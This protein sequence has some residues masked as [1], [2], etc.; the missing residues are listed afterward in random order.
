[1]APR[2]PSG[3]AQGQ[4]RGA[5]S[6]DL[7]L[8]SSH[9]REQGIGWLSCHPRPAPRPSLAKLKA[10]PRTL[11][12]EG[13]DPATLP[14]PRTSGPWRQLL[15]D[16][17]SAWASPGPRSLCTCPHGPSAP[18]QQPTALCA[19]PCSD[20]HTGRAWPAR[21]AGRPEHKQPGKLLSG[22]TAW[23][24]C[25]P[26]RRRRPLPVPNVSLTQVL[27][28][29]RAGSSPQERTGAPASQKSL[30]RS[31]G[32]NLALATGPLP[33]QAPEVKENSKENTF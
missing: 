3:A 9:S 15:E 18:P 7:G 27:P 10:I 12:G 2:A 13:H 31:S 14:S 8:R 6:S 22:P 17:A 24:P 30:W 21:P 32:P 5:A 33:G 11:L 26:E 29:R 25:E 4:A 20:P 23:S 19:S 28:G 16:R 1:M